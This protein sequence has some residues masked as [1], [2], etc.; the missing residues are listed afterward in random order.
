M[1]TNS[2]E[3]AVK[4]TIQ[5][6]MCINFSEITSTTTIK[7]L[8]FDSMDFLDFIYKLEE[9]TNKEIDIKKIEFKDVEKFTVQDLICEIQKI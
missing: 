7:E 1:N 2:L 8:G 6:I 4:S 3:N 9:K 5:E